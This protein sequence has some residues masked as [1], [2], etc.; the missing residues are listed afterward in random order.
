LEPLE[1]PLQ[2]WHQWE[3]NT[4]QQTALALDPDRACTLLVT[5]E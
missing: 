3:A 4:L 2:R 1:Q 5:P